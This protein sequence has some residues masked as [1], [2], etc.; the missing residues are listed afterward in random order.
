[1]FFVIALCGLTL[2]WWFPVAGHFA[3]G[4]RDLAHHDHGVRTRVRSW[5]VSACVAYDWLVGAFLVG[6]VC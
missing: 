2:S 1:V 6:Y 5:Y 4:F 3:H